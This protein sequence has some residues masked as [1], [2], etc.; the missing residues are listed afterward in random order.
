MD[1]H[2]HSAARITTYSREGLRFDVG[3]EGPFGGEPVVLSRR[4]SSR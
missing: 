3:D 2:N 4:T 1:A